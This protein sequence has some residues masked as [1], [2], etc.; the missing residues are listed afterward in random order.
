[1][2]A[3]STENQSKDLF[4]FL[5]SDRNVDL[6]A[7]SLVA[8]KAK[9][10]LFMLKEVEERKQSWP[11]FFAFSLLSSQ[12]LFLPSPTLRHALFTHSPARASKEG[13]SP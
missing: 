2:E 9:R 6:S 11:R 13:A 7:S 10:N 4:C 3:N 12:S 5:N 1:M 8:Q